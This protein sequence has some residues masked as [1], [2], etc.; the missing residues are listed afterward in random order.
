[1]GDGLGVESVILTKHNEKPLKP[2]N[3]KDGIGLF[4]HIL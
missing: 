3:E 4:F 2:M 1:M